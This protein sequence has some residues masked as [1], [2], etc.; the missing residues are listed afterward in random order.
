MSNC[1]IIYDFLYIFPYKTNSR[2]NRV[3]G[4]ICAVNQD[5]KMFQR[6]ELSIVFSKTKIF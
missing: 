5:S 1:A 4:N 6:R 3:K 2:A